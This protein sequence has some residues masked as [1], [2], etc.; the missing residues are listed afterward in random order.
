MKKVY[1]LFGTDFEW[2]EFLNRVVFTK[3]GIK[4]IARNSRI[5]RDQR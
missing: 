4:L 3:S 5:H 1:N 2:D